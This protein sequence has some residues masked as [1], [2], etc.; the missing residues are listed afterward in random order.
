MKKLI[1]VLFIML[2]SN[3][4][5]V[6]EQP[7]LKDNRVNYIANILAAITSANLQDIL[8]VESY[9][10][11]V[12]RNN[13]SSSLSSLRTQC[14]IQ[15]ASDNCKS[16]RQQS[17]QSKCELYSDTIVANRLSE[18][19]FIPRSER[20]RLLKNSR[21][22]SRDVL[23]NRLEQKYSRLVTQFALPLQDEC[24]LDDYPCVAEQLD[25][26]CLDYTNK[27]NLSWQYCTSAIIWFIG[28]S[29]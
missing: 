19:V 24:K 20:Y 17:E 25:S 3:V 27:Q 7:Y 23:R 1:I 4:G 16:L 28:T 22:N 9:I 12:D 6:Q 8:N 11:V 10:S 14:L 21:G 29:R 2:W 18:S 5:F 26:F 15:Y 13:C